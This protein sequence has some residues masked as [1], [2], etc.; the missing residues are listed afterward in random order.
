MPNG[1]FIG[2][3]ELYWIKAKYRANRYMLDLVIVG[4]A[5]CLYTMTA[6]WMETKNT[7][8]YSRC[9]VVYKRQHLYFD[10]V[11]HKR[12]IHN[13]ARIWVSLHPFVGPYIRPFVRPEP[14]GR[15]NSAATDSLEIKVVG[16]VLARRCGTPWSVSHRTH[17]GCVKDVVP[18]HADYAMRLSHWAASP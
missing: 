17:W 8:R 4:V 11:R 7:K 13:S 16:I 14:C 2:Q 9:T 18:K 10:F 5:I 12:V 3:K 15:R 1:A 6:G